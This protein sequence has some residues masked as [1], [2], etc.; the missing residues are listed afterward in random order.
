MALTKDVALDM[1]VKLESDLDAH[2]NKGTPSVY[3]FAGYKSGVP[4]GMSKTVNYH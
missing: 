4:V 1:L 2:Q 3:Q